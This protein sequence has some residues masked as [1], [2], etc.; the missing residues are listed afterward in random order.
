MRT[1]Y[2]DVLA[3]YAG[4]DDETRSAE[5]ADF[6]LDFGYNSTKLEHSDVHYEEARP[7]SG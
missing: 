7:S 4:L 5:L 3:W 6:A 1:T 2:E